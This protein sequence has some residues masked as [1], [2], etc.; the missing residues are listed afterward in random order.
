M[1]SFPATTDPELAGSRNRFP[2]LPFQSG[3]FFDRKPIK[4]LS[5]LRDTSL[6]DP[7]R[8][9]AAKKYGENNVFNYLNRILI[10][11]KL[12][13]KPRLAFKT[14]NINILEKK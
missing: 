4:L 9:T 1:T 5:S 3:D 13:C 12:T 2:L 8:N 14:M 10:D 7:M 11:M 6:N